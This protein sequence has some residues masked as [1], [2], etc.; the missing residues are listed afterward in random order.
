[1]ND[2][3]KFVL[4][5]L[6]WWWETVGFCV[7]NPIQSWRSKSSAII[8]KQTGNKGETLRTN[9]GYWLVVGLLP[10]ASDQSLSPTS[11]TQDV[12][13]LPSLDNLPLLLYCLFS[14]LGPRDTLIS[15]SI[16][17]LFVHFYFFIINYPSRKLQV[18]KTL[19]K[20][21]PT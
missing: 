11:I 1:M 3:L 12:T 10:F 20:F 5:F 19:I 21:W 7:A 6:L 14:L 17:R 15:F 18:I 8:S 16:R 13:R 4:L 9:L 2:K